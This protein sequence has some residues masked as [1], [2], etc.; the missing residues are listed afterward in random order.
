MPQKFQI[1]APPITMSEMENISESQRNKRPPKSKHRGGKFKRLEPQNIVAITSSPRVFSCFQNTK[2]FQFYK[3]IKQVKSN[4]KLTR[5]L[6]LN[7]QNKYSD[8][9]GIKFEISTMSISEATS[10][11]S[12]GEKWFKNGKLEIY[13]FFRFLKRRYR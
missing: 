3:R 4:P 1:S 5:L 12:V 7:L 2:C 6:I 11:P 8:L 13:L 10:I 9:V